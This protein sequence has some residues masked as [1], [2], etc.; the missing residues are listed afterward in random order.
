MN[1][2]PEYQSRSEI[3]NIVRELTRG[4]KGPG[5]VHVMSAGKCMKYC[6]DTPERGWFLKPNRKWDGDKNLSSLLRE[7]QIQTLGNI[8]LPGKV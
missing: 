7:S 6:V 8:Q 1:I 3:Q 2:F 5:K 4:V